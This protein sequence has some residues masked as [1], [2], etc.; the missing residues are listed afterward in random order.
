MEEIHSYPA[1]QAPSKHIRS[2][3]KENVN[4]ETPTRCMDFIVRHFTPTVNFIQAVEREN[5]Y[6][7]R[8]DTDAWSPIWK[9]TRVRKG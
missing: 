1:I 6:S 4:R 3:L 9:Q 7:E 8:D 5:N 2:W